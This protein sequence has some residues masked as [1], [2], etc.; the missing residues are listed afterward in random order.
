MQ[1]RE[2]EHKDYS[3]IEEWADQYGIVQREAGLPK[4]GFIID[5]VAAGFIYATDSDCCWIENVIANKKATKEE[6]A[7]AFDL[8]VPALMQKAE[9]LGFRVAYATTNNVK[10]IL[11]CKEYGAIVKPLQMLLTKHL[12]PS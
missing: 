6:K 9:E 7:E 11:K 2:Y 1:V 3:Q 10:L 8:L 4:T 5:N 12:S